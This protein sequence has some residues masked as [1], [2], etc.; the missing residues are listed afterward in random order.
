[1]KNISILFATTILAFNITIN[2]QTA[3]FE[4]TIYFE[5]AVGNKD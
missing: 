1:M 2:A 4:T 5:D 3:Q